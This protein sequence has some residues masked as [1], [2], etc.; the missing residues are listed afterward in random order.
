MSQQVHKPV[1]KDKRTTA[2]MDHV[3]TTGSPSSIGAHALFDQMKGER[4]V[5]EAQGRDPAGISTLAPEDPDAQRFNADNIRGALAGLKDPPKIGRYVFL[6]R[7]GGGG[8]GVVIAAYDPKLDRRVAIKLIHVW[9]RDDTEHRK[10]MEREAQA[11]AKLS[12]P[13]V[14]TVYEVGEHEGQLFL[15][16]EFVKGQDLRGWL[17]NREDSANWRVV[18]EMFIQAGQGLA[19]AHRAGLVH[20]DF[21]PANVFVG[22][23]GRV[24]VGDF[25]LA[26]QELEADAEILTIRARLESEATA[27]SHELTATGAT[28]GTP[29]YMAPEQFAGKPTDARTDQFSFCIALWEAL[30]GQRPFAGTSLADLIENVSKGRCVPPPADQQVPT[31]LRKALERGLSLVRDE[32]YPTTEA[33]LA[34]LQ[35]DPTRRRRVLAGL[36][37]VAVAF[38]AWFGVRSYLEAQQVA[39]CE[40]DGAS[41]ADVWNTDVQTKLRE[42]LLATGLSYAETTAV[43]VM[44][45]FEAQAEVWRDAR[46]EACLHTRVWRDWTEDTLDQS[47]WCLD[48]RRMQLESLVAELTGAST[49]EKAV[50]AAAGLAQVKPCLDINYLRTLPPLPQDRSRVKAVRRTLSLAGARRAAGRYKEGLDGAREALAAAEE[51]GWPPL[52]AAARSLYGDLLDMSGA[53]SEAEVALERAYFEAITVGAQEVAA[54][55]AVSLVFTVGSKQ[56]RHNEGFM[57]SK[58]ADAVLSVL[59][60]EEDSLRR[61]GALNNLAAVHLS[62]GAYREAKATYERALAIREKILGPDHP[63]VATYLNNLASV[64]ISLGAY[65]EARTRYER[66]LTIREKSLGPDHP[67]FAGTLSNLAAVHVSMGKYAEGKDLHEKALLIKQKAL[68]PEHPDVASSL[69]SLASVHASTGEFAEARELYERALII[70][71]KALGRNH[72]SYADSLSNLASVHADTKRPQEAKALFAKALAIKEKTLGPD[73]PKIAHTLSNLANLHASAGELEEA[74]TLYMRALAINEKSLGPNHPEVETCLTGL[75][76]V[77]LDEHRPADAVVLGERAVAIQTAANGPAERLGVASFM[78]ASALWDAPAGHGRD[79]SRA[80]ALA[81]QS[82]DAFLEVKGK[83]EKLAEVEAFLAKHGGGRR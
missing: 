38:P 51:L 34:A 50:L 25:G 23:D 21:K 52:T 22:Q 16:M 33:M 55:T 14:V 9:R 46:T 49:V 10:R 57:W 1:D 18:L 27:L 70:R 36:V 20:R 19:A 35:A 79:R 80:L 63:L 76:K 42:G 6:E 24:R 58:H 4:L 15:A 31:W 56:A 43:N 37:A 40:A 30:Y 75:A 41:I 44:P 65:E 61:A 29:A 77:A 47:V 66:A 45:Y 81:R 12:H 64:Y 72:P 67:A 28:L 53:A 5:A 7:L 3:N 69:H 48:E 54:D 73:H 60:V 2:D 13:N 71:E 82:R 78:L 83:G 11:M 8:M 59:G 74:N 39:M 62:A 68:G 32:R 17:G 26:R